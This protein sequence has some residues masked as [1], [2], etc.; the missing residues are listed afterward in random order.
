MS[1]MNQKE[2]VFSATMSVLSDMGLS[3]D[4]GQDIKSFAEIKEIRSKVTAIVCESFRSGAI[5]LDTTYDE[6]GLKNYVSGL[7][8]NWYRKDTRLNGG[9]KYAPKNPG[10]RAGTGNVEVRELKKLYTAQKAA[11]AD[12]ETLATIQEH[13]DSKVAESKVA[14]APVVDFSKIDPS[15]LETL[16]IS[17]E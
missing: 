15:L 13:I 3:F 12:E 4:Q 16:G 7:V 14:K 8:N 9:G 1:Q 11:G 5:K 10:S 2:G 17:A 6:A